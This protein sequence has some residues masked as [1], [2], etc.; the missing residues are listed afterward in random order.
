MA[1]QRLLVKLLNANAMVPRRQTPGAAGYDLHS[2]ENVTVPAC[3]RARVGTGVAVMLPPGTYGRVAP[4]S[5]LAYLAG[6]DVG[7]GVIDGDYRGEVVVILFNHGGVSVDVKIG[8]RIAQ[9]LIEPVF[10]PDVE[11]VESLDATE[12]S[13]GGFGSTG[14]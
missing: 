5:S 9:L 11:V 12:R 6:V 1:N 7:G 8:D 13:A 4:R 3:G 2:A 14:K 10:T